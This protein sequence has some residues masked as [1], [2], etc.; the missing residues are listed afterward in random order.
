MPSSKIQF[1]ILSFIEISFFSAAKQAKKAKSQ[2]K[3][4]TQPAGLKVS[5]YDCQLFLMNFLFSRINQ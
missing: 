1:F 4:T 2:Q 5:S 3:K